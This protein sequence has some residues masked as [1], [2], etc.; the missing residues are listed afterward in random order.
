MSPSQIA[1]YQLS[2]YQTGLSSLSHFGLE[3][4]LDWGKEHQKLEQCSVEPLNKDT[5]GTSRIVL[6][7]EVV[8]FQR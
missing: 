7:R 8:L 1:G 3:K 6:S 2:I 4:M 5:F